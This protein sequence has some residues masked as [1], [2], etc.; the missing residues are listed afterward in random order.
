MILAQ[1]PIST[2]EEYNLDADSLPRQPFEIA[3]SHVNSSIRSIALGTASLW[4]TVHVD[5]GAQD[6]GTILERTTA[7]LSRSSG[8]LLDLRI[9]LNEAPSQSDNHLCEVIDMIAEESIRWRKLAIVAENDGITDVIAGIRERLIEDKQENLTPE[10]EFLSLSVD[11]SE[12]SF[13]NFQGENGGSVSHLREQHPARN[14]TTSLSTFHRIALQ[15]LPTL[16][17]LRLRG[18]AIYLFQPTLLSGLQTLHLDQTKAIPFSFDFFNSFMAA[19]PALEHLSI[20]GDIV[21]PSGHNGGAFEQVLIPVLGDGHIQPLSHAARYAEGRRVELGSQALDSIISLLELRSLRVCGTTDSVFKVL[22]TKLEAP[23]LR[24]FWVKDAQEHDLDI[25][26]KVPC[27]TPSTASNSDHDRSEGPQGISLPSRFT[28]MQSLTFDNSNLSQSVYRR[29]SQT[30]PHIVE[31]ASYS[32]L[33]VGTAASLL[34]DGT[35]WPSLRALA[36]VFDTD[37]YADEDVLEELVKRRRESGCPID[38]LRI[39]VDEADIEDLS[40]ANAQN[41]VIVMEKAD[42]IDIWPPGRRYRDIDDILF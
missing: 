29:L 39:G 12:E 25:F 21:M 31:F 10:L 35:M 15:Q 36:F 9:E 19:C 22:S 2:D 5:T 40:E 7:Y 8:H 42:G 18:L 1:E 38:E 28:Q 11:Y 4:S 23:K 26:W 30:F 16:S 14:V 37:L 17:F 20:Y 3:I 34:A 33:E 6:A 41:P 24:N 32:S 13:A 27:T